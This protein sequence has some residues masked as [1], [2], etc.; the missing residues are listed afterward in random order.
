MKKQSKNHIYLIALLAM[1]CVGYA[2]ASFG[3]PSHGVK[4]TKHN[5]STTGAGMSSIQSTSETEIC[6]FC[7]TPHN[8]V[9]GR[10]FLWNRTNRVTDF[11]MYTASPTLNFDKNH[12]KQVST[13]SKMCLSC[14]D[15]AGAINAMANPRPGGVPQVSPT[16]DQLGDQ[17]NELA[18]SLG[19][20]GPNLGEAVVDPPGG[21]PW[22]GGGDPYTSGNLLLNDHP[23]SFV[24]AESCNND[25]TI[26]KGDGASCSDATVGGLPLWYENLDN[27]G[28]YRVECVTCHDPHINYNTLK[29]GKEEFRPF[30]RKSNAS[31]SLCFTCHNK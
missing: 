17:Y 2:T 23:I 26:N 15:G 5:F 4:Y 18:D 28:G 6:I 21:G 29:G 31:S 9:P 22:T 19:Y 3:A 27:F 25:T 10:T 14:H 7:H 13:V 11:L 12:G 8:A 20:Y 30:L 16:F 24:Y 1:L